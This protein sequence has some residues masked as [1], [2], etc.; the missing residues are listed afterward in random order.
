M[1][2]SIRAI[3]ILITQI[4]YFMLLARI[5]LSF[6][7]RGYSANRNEFL[8]SVYRFLWSVTEPVL[9]P[10]RKLM[11]SMRAGGGAQFDFSPLIALIAIWILQEL[12]V[13]YVNF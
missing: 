1:N 9:K 3:L 7:V 11:P 12:I 10:I 2:T 4:Y 5:I 13:R 8:D 6:F